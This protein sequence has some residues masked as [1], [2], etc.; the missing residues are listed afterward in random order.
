MEHLSY[1]FNLAAVRKDVQL[2]KKK[3]NLYIITSIGMIFSKLR[4]RSR[5]AF[6]CQCSRG[7][8]RN[9]CALIQYAYASWK[10]CCSTYSHISVFAEAILDLLE[11]NSFFCF[12]IALCAR[13]KLVSE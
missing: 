6:R 13:Y 10:L 7:Q 1:V 3:K 8:W 12:Y 2:K 4:E 9:V 11:P 5:P